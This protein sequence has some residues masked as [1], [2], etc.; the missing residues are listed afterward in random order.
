M[1]TTTQK[2]KELNNAIWKQLRHDITRERSYGQEVSDAIGA[3]MT[4][5]K[6]CLDRPYRMRST[7]GPYSLERIATLRYQS[8]RYISTAIRLMERFKA[9]LSDSSQGTEL[10][11]SKFSSD[12]SS[13]HVQGLEYMYSITRLSANLAEQA[14]DV[15]YGLDFDL[16]SKSELLLLYDRLIAICI[17]AH[18]YAEFVTQRAR[19]WHEDITICGGAGVDHLYTFVV[20]VADNVYTY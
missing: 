8:E 15:V 13:A 6:C 17:M 14:L 9:L 20:E 2:F 19:D 7:T 18:V 12:L 10:R 4:H 3:S 5:F 11:R 16:A 1:N